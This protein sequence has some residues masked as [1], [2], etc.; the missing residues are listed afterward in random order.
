MIGRRRWLGGMAAALVAAGT[1][2]WAMA[3]DDAVGDLSRTVVFGHFRGDDAETLMAALAELRRRNDPGIA[4]ALILALRYNRPAA[5]PVA[6][7]LAAITGEAKARTWFDWMLWQEAHPEIVPHPSFERLKIELFT[8]IDPEFSRF[9]PLTPNA[10]IRLE[11]V[12][13]GGVAAADGIPA[14]TNPRLLDAE[15]AT[16]L[17]P[18]EAVFGVVINGDARA[19]PLRILDWHEM[20]NDVVG[21]VPVSLA[22]CTLCG[23]GILYDGRVEG[24]ER[25]LTFGSSG[26]LFRSNKLMYDR[27]TDSLWNQFTGRPV[28]GPLAGSGTGTALRMLP[29]VL[30]SWRDWRAAHPGT[31]VLSPDTGH[32]RDYAPDAAYGHYFSSPDLMF[33]ARADERTR[34]LKDLIFGIRTAGGAK[35]W[36][37]DAFRGSPVVNDGVGLV[38]VVL[39]GNAATRTVRAYRRDGR[40]FAAGPAPE[41]LTSGG[42]SWRITETALEGP[43][44]TRLPRVAGHVAYWFAWSA[45]VDGLDDPPTTR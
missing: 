24:L 21:G 25:P 41:L 2:G 10:E 38:D 4:A 19:Y 15:D 13:W 20:L 18:G 28:S 32:L 23:S 45:F 26:L 31:R 9:L 5:E 43:L 27:A 40:T 44:G 16:Y 29:V 7:A 34:A 33:P 17:I 36:P 30:A 6:D 11:E 12:V 3:G 1:P 22:Y 14:L 35:A 39:I 8:A 42:E 37:L